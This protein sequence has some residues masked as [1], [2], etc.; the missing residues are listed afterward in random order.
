MRAHYDRQVSEYDGLWTCRLNGTIGAGA[1][2]IG[3]YDDTLPTS[4]INF[5]TR[6][7]TVLYYVKSVATLFTTCL[8]VNLLQFL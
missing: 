8:M 3:I 2:H 1:F 7:I 4:K 6:H 5:F